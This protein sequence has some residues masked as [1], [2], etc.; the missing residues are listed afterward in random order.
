MDVYFVIRNYLVVI[1]KDFTHGVPP[2]QLP[3]VQRIRT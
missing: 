2:K 1:K 3:I